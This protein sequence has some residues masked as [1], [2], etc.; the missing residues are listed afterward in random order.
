M[1]IVE[2]SYSDLLNVINEKQKKQSGEGLIKFIIFIK[3]L[4][5]V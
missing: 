4:E 5:L 2:T 3:N 1:M